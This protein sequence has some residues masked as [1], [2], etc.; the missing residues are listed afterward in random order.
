MARRTAPYGSWRSPITAEMIAAGTVG[1]SQVVLDGE[2]ILWMEG[3][4]AERGRNVVV[5][6]PPGGGPAQDVTAAGHSA[7]TRVHEYGGGAYAAS[8][9]AVY[10][11]NF[12]DQRLYRHRPGSPPEALTPAGA[13]RRYADLEIDSRRGRLIAVREDHSG[14]ADSAE[15]VNEIVSVCAEP[16][17]SEPV[18]VLVSGAD[19]YSNP[20]V[21]P[22]GSRLCWLQWNHPNMPWDG[23][24]LWTGDLGAGGVTGPRLVAGGEGESIFQPEWSPS[25]ALFFVSDRSGWWNIYRAAGAGADPEAL[26]PTEAEFATPAW[27]FGMRTYGFAAEDRIVC[28]YARSGEWSL[29]MLDARTGELAPFDLP[30]SDFSCVR[31]GGGSAV[32]RAGSAT[33]SP[34]IVRLDLATGEAEPVSPPPSVSVPEG[35]LSVPEAMEFPTEGGAT[36]HCFFYP[37]ASAEFEGPESERPPLLVK[38]HGGPTAAATSTLSMGVQYWTSRGVAVADVNYGGSTGYGTEYRRRLSGEWGVVDVADCVAAAR[39]LARRGDVDGDRLAIDGGSAGGFT[40]LAALTFRDVFRAGAS[41][42]GICDLEAL[43]RDTHKFESRYLDGL[44]AP[45]PER[46]DVWRERSPINHIGRLRR[47]VIIFQGLE[48]RIVPPNQAEMIV[49]ALRDRGVPVAYLAYEGEQHGFR[50]AANIR[51]TLE[52]ELYFYSRIFGFELAEPV[53]AVRIENL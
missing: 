33:L 29:G 38:I 20:R 17:A 42:Y 47:P 18:R 53:E 19:F 16:G 3:R 28:A 40:T 6:R 45:Y 34:R 1:L 26:C 5:R 15:A 41:F 22:D 48:D 52:G 14:A 27:V 24:E 51:R 12:D 44:I 50:Q 35:A 32:F 37:P 11:A 10:Y 13:D 7:R 21:S 31:V 25:G 49:A 4:P 46:A 9:G 30:Y 8:G 36:A 39:H 2:D 23:C 43:A